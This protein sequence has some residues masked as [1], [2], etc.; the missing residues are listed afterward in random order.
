MD[1]HKR[2]IIK[3]CTYRVLSTVITFLV[4]YIL[5]RKVM[6]AASI[7]LSDTVIKVFFYYWHERVWEKYNFGRKVTPT[8]D[9]QI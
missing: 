3:A 6:L 7:S 1:S 9:Y 5:T 2:S 4:S 8:Q